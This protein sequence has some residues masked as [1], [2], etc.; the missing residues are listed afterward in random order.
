M[1]TRTLFFLLAALP[2]LSFASV[3]GNTENASAS[4]NET[5][6]EEIA[7]ENWMLEPTNWTASTETMETES[8]EPALV[9]ESWMTEPADKSW[10]NPEAEQ[11]EDLEVES[12]MNDPSTWLHENK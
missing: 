4:S 5:I 9:L 7:L 6:V 1:K 2:V 3:P 10:N 11:E 8:E 12:W